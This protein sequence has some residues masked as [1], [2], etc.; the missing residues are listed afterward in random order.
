MKNSSV[1]EKIV[2]GAI[3]AGVGTMFLGVIAATPI[4][5]LILQGNMN[6]G[7]FSITNVATGT[8]ASNAVAKGYVDTF[9]G[10]TN[11]H[12]LGTI[13]NGPTT[14]AGYGITDAASSTQGAKADT[15]LQPDGNGSGLTGLT[16]TQVGLGNVDNTADTAKPVSTAQQ[17]ALDLKQNAAASV[18]QAEAEAGTETALRMWSP[19]R[20]AQAI[21]YQVPTAT[22]SLAGRIEIATDA[23]ESAGTLAN[24]ASTPLGN[25]T[26]FPVRLWETLGAKARMVNLTNTVW[27]TS[28]GTGSSGLQVTT[29]GIY[30][31]TGSGTNSTIQIR[32]RSNNVSSLFPRFSQ[33]YNVVNTALPNYVALL[34]ACDGMDANT[35]LYFN[36]LDAYDDVA[37]GDLTVDGSFGFR[38]DGTSLKLTKYTTAGGLTVGSSVAT[39]IGGASA[40]FTKV[41]LLTD[42]AGN[43]SCKINGVIVTGLTGLATSTGHNSRGI[44][45]G[46]TNGATAAANRLYI[47]WIVTA[48]P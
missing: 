9:A 31:Y 38:C 42:G 30:L 33:I 20:V 6:A 43:L 23:E 2:N 45:I 35:T 47:P 18:S 37:I 11:I 48:T 34:F 15:A 1:R 21:A 39:I 41:E 40:T 24:R 36:V 12:T 29:D 26:A 27:I 32:N 5:D 28:S 13:T 25:A 22:D 3:A 4:K 14:R 46:L 10:S 17:T 8:G 16:K 19:Q 44:S 7:G